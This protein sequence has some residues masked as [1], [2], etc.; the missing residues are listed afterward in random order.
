M[1]ETLYTIE[2]FLQALN[3]GLL[4]GTVYGLM[5]AGLAL[6]FGVTRII[7]FAQ[8]DFM[9]LGMYASY[10]I[11]TMLGVQ[12]AL[13]EV[14]GPFV[15][16]LAAGPVVFVFGYFVHRTLIARVSG[17]RTAG[18]QAEGH[19]AQLMLTLG[20]ALILQNGGLFVFGSM[21]MSVQTPLSSSAWA[22]G[23][24]WGDYVEVFI[25]KARTV[26]ALLSIAAVAVLSSVI[27]RTRLGILLRASADNP[28]AA[29]Y[30]G[31][32][33]E[34]AH[35]IAFA[36]GVG[37]TAFAGGLLAANLPFQPYIGLD[38]V[39]IM[40]TG[41]VLGGLG[42]IA[43]AFWGGL[44]IG[45]VQQLSTLVLPTQL[46]AAAIFVFFLIVVFVRPQGFFGRSGERI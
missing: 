26:S 31:I 24:L 7:N 17:V 2:D 39:I 27:G 45:L 40:Y 3:A 37:V 32:D 14:V 9:M 44:T 46:Q 5:C 10:G 4:V 1:I 34:R 8:G 16:A 21:L 30:M 15:A 19:Y 36:T 42:S 13:G 29:L 20:I 6:I 18:L 28:D 41:V 35:R 22:V 25:N 38:Y 33:V 23:P 12:A 11:F 43:G